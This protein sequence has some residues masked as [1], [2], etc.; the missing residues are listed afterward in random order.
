MRR[1]AF[2]IAI[3]GMFVLV[4]LLS[5]KPVSVIGY[6]DLEDLELNTRVE[7]V[8][9]VV[10]EKIIYGDNKVLVLDGGIELVCEGVGGFVGNEVRVVGVVNEYDG[11]KQVSVL[12]IYFDD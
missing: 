6:E 7:V 2:V 5:Q 11:K 12:E 4:L 9:E 1:F 10:S 3:L 8:G